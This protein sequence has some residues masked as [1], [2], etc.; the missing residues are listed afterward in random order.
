MCILEGES[1]VEYSGEGSLALLSHLLLL[2]VLKVE[3]LEI[4]K[5]VGT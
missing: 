1:I 2:K 3:L 5:V 4:L